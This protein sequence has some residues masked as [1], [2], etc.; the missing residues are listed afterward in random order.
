MC[1]SS[2]ELVSPAI[3]LDESLLVVGQCNPLVAPRARADSVRVSTACWCWVETDLTD[4][5]AL[6][7][8]FESCDVPGDIVRV[9]ARRCEEVLLTVG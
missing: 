7:T 4:D 2:E 5:V 3:D 1:H 9:G 8:E 6:G